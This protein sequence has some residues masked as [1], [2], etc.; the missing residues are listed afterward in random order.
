MLAFFK[1][2]QTDLASATQQTKIPIAVKVSA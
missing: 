1:K 2:L